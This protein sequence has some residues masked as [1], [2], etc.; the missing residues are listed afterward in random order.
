MTTR[1]KAQVCVEDLV[2]EAETLLRTTHSLVERLRGNM[3]EFRVQEMRR[4]L[5]MGRIRRS[6]ERAD[7]SLQASPS[8]GG[9]DG[10]ADATVEDIEEARGATIH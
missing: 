9:P 8:L 1:A 2:A 7:L 6:L 10:P 3:V 4:Q 5:A